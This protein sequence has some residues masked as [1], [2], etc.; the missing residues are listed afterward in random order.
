M[1]DCLKEYNSK[2]IT[3]AEALDQIQSDMNIYVGENVAEPAAILREQAKK[4]E[5]W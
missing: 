2:K 3:V 1:K 5:L 4:L